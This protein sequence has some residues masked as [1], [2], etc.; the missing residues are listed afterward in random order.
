MGGKSSRSAGTAEKGRRDGG[1]GG[2]QNRDRR[3]A[4]ERAVSGVL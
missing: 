2:D 3:G 4:G 1:E